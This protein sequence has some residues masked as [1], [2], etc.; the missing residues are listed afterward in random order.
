MPWRRGLQNCLNCTRDA[1]KRNGAFEESRHRHFIGSVERDTSGTA[2]LSRLVSQPK[3]R[4]AFKIRRFEV[5]LG[6][7]REIEG[8]F[9]GDPVWIAESVQDGKA[10]VGNRDLR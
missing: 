4:K 10:H 9:A 2:R 8:E 1:A 5:Q 3:A 7:G 6:K